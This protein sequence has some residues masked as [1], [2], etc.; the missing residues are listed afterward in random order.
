MGK[1]KNRVESNLIILSCATMGKLSYTSSNL[2]GRMHIN[3]KVKT[4][5]YI[6]QKNKVNL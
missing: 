4:K 1:V 3:P 2:N 6:K 5:K